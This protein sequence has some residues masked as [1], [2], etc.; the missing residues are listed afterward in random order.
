[1]TTDPQL[2]ARDIDQAEIA[3]LFARTLEGEFDDDGCWNAIHTLQSIGGRRVF[4]FAMGW[5]QSGDVR[6][7]VRGVDVLAQIGKTPE[8]P[9]TEFA[10]ES[11][12]V[13]ESLLRGDP[14]LE[15]KDSAIIALH[16]L[17][18]PAAIPLICSFRADPDAEIRLSV[19]HALDAPF[20]DDPQSVEALM[21]LT[22]DEDEQVRNWATF[23]LGVQS[24]ADTPAIRE[25]LAARLDDPYPDAREEAM[26][27]LAKRKDPRALPLLI[28]LLTDKTDSC[29]AEEAACSLLDLDVDET[30]RSASEYITALRAR[31]GIGSD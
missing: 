25:A 28:E 16:H 10:G 31:F 4:D 11:Y 14:A 2:T 1:M 9:T 18:N 27:A 23:A 19:A 5:C 13:I 8:H 12:P 6:K 15:L 29:R 26:A 20:A 21:A 24:D 17:C 3:L 7:Q 22:R 30:E